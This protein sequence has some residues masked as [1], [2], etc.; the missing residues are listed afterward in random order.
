MLG[1]RYLGLTPEEILEMLRK[2]KF[3]KSRRLLL[4]I[5]RCGCEGCDDF[6][7]DISVNNNTVTWKGWYEF[8]KA[9]YI[10]ALQEMK[11]MASECLAKHKTDFEEYK[12]AVYECLT[13]N[14]AI[15]S[16]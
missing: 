1:N 10:S 11:K 6:F 5:C 9:E 3:F 13:Q 2:N 15:P 8:D 14:M 7:V 12:K 16:T 4:G